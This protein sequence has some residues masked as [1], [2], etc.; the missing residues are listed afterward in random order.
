MV[1][2]GST[3]GLRAPSGPWDRSDWHV[4]TEEAVNEADRLDIVLRCRNRAFIAVIENKVDAREQDKQCERYSDWL[5]DQTE[6]EFRE[7]IFLTP[8]GHQPESGHAGQ[9]ICLSY[10]EHIK[11]WLEG[12][13]RIRN[14]Q[15]PR[16]R[17]AIEQYLQI[18][19]SL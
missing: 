17:M 1:R 11:T 3:C 13:M 10:R 14:I 8:D 16:L 19:Q 18:V 15:A 4:T 9:W 6:F 5:N 2:S 12:V 7:Q